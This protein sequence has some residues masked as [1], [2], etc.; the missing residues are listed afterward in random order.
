LN[1]HSHC[2]FPV[3]SRWRIR[4]SPQLRIRER[5][6]R[7]TVPRRRPCCAFVSEI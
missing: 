4:E 2:P 1:M 3:R 6:G 5:W 7:G